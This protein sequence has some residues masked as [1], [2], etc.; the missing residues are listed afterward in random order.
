MVSGID[1]QFKQDRQG[2]IDNH[3]GSQKSLNAKIAQLR[4]ANNEQK[5]TMAQNAASEYVTQRSA[6]NAAFAQMNAGLANTGIGAVSQVT[7]IGLTS[8]S[9]A[10]QAEAK[11]AEQA[12]QFTKN[13]TLNYKNLAL[14]KETAKQSNLL[15]YDQLLASGM[16]TT[17]NWFSQY[18]PEAPVY[19]QLMMLYAKAQEAYAT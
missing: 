19:G 9:F 18:I 14:S 11:L 13:L 6:V 2:L 1:A 10:V 3:K 12:R 5:Y 17:A 15:A 8:Q 4:F 7:G 16:N